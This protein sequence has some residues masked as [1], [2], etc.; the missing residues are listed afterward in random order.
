[1]RARLSRGGRRCGLHPLAVHAARPPRDVVARSGLLRTAIGARGS[2][3]S[4]L[5]PDARH[6]SR[7]RSDRPVGGLAYLRVPCAALEHTTPF[8]QFAQGAGTSRRATWRL[9]TTFTGM[10]EKAR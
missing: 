4:G 9:F 8:A 5:D 6:P 3:R 1:V 10:F 2:S 7:P